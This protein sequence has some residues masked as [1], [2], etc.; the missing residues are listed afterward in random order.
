MSNL[1]GIQELSLLYLYGKLVPTGVV[2]VY[3]ICLYMGGLWQQV[4]PCS[5]FLYLCAK[6]VPTGVIA[7]LLLVSLQET[8]AHGCR[9]VLGP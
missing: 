2:I 8:Y 7:F 5:Y 6:L 9:L 1:F 4:L 3:L